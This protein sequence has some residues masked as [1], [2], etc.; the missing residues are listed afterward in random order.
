VYRAS[1][2]LIS[3]NP[4]KYKLARVVRSVRG[5]RVLM[6]LERLVKG[7]YVRAVNYHDVPP[8][9]AFAFEY[10][11]RFYSRHFISVDYAALDRLQSGDW[12]AS[13]PGLILSFD[14]GTR[15][16][17]EVV[18]PLLEK[19]GFTGWFM[20]PGGLL[21]TPPAAQT[22]YAREHSIAHAGFDYG[23]E[24]IAM[25]WDE[26]RSLSR[27]H[28]IGSHTW[29]HSRLVE[30]LGAREIE[31]QVVRAKSRLEERLGVPVSIFA[32]V[33]G[34]EVS[35]SRSAASAIVAAGHTYSFMTNHQVIRQR[36]PP[37]QLQRSNIEASD[38]EA[39]MRF[40]LTGLMDILY[41][42]KRRRV[43]RVTSI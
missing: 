2:Y 18:A 5:D 9:M 42:A 43:N 40:Q 31:D 11:L 36:T 3:V 1:I 28:I 16:H 23:D 13:K 15:S 17:A 26:L 27:R 12:S 29:D 34:E 21:D 30:G 32:W 10:Q 38:P 14:D 24:R 19:Y 20:V 8:N 41:T 22:E 33:G 35:Y 37:H 6:A 39:I 25:T 7:P 4:K